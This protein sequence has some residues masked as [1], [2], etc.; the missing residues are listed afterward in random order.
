MNMLE[1]LFSSADGGI[2]QQLASQFGVNP[3]QATSALTAL[4]PALA[5]GMQEKL[6]S[7]AGGGLLDM[8]TSGGLSKFADDPSTLTSPAAVAQ[9]NS[10]LGSIFGGGSLVA[11][12][13]MVAQKAGIG[14][15]IVEKMLPIVAA[16]LGGMLAKNGGGA[17][18]I[19]S[20]LGTLS[21]GAEGGVL[22][23]VKGLAAKIFG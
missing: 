22:G 1:T 6:S 5:G 20:M 9:G 17:D 12:V 2:V 8:L 15:P 3:G 23:T 21:A 4:V 19:T 16:F 10:L 7:G 14:G 13:S 11:F 18:G